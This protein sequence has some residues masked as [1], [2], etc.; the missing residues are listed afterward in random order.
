MSKFRSAEEVLDAVR[1]CV[2]EFGNYDVRPGVNSKGFFGDTPVFAA[3]T[4]GDVSAVKLLLEAG[5]DVNVSG[6]RGATPL[7]HAIRMAEFPIARVLIAAGAN[8]EARDDEGKAPRDWCWEGE[9][10]SLFG[11][12]PNLPSPGN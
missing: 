6:E 5:A 7:H 1:E 11:T 8:C 3:I 4:W 12:R 10:P 2:V 9:W